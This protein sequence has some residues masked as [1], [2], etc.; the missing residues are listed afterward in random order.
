MNFLRVND[1]ADKLQVSRATIWAWS[2]AGK[3]PKPVKLGAGVTRW[4]EQDVD[5]W[6][7]MQ[8]NK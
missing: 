3:F 6:I 2:K 7:E 1:V 4:S 5:D 8:A